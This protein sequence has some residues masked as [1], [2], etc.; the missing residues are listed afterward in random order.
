MVAVHLT[1]DLL[2]LSCSLIQNCCT[3]ITLIELIPYLASSLLNFAGSFFLK[4]HPH[5]NF[6]EIKVHIMHSLSTYWFV[7]ILPHLHIR[8]FVNCVELNKILKKSRG[9]KVKRFNY[10][11]GCN[12]NVILL[13]VFVLLSNDAMGLMVQWRDMVSLVHLFIRLTKLSLLTVFMKIISGVRYLFLLL[14]DFF[15]VTCKTDN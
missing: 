15:F 9:V 4:Q 13:R 11:S 3:N 7:E 6:D 10:L 8:V 5:F 2:N 12:V 1:A 14:C